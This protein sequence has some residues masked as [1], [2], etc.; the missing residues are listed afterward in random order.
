MKRLSGGVPDS[1]SGSSRSRLTG[2]IAAVAAAVLLMS[3]TAVADTWL[4]ASASTTGARATCDV[5]TSTRYVDDDLAYISCTIWDTS[6]DG[7]AVYV[8]WQQDGYRTVSLY[9]RN[10]YPTSFVRTDGRYNSDGS[11]GTLRWRVC[12]D[13][14][15]YSDNCSGWRVYYPQ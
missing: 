5:W 13:R 3:N 12:R 15:F 1:Q 10:G 2:L 14:Q 4:T 6:A 9:H 7:D 11:F 8:G